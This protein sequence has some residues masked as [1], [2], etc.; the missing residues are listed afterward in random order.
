MDRLC[1]GLEKQQ[2][3]TTY[4]LLELACYLK[5]KYFF[6]KKRFLLTGFHSF[7]STDLLRLIHSKQ[8]MLR[9]VLMQVGYNTILLSETIN[10]K[11]AHS[12]A[13][14]CC[15]S[16]IYIY[17][18]FLSTMLL[19]QSSFLHFVDV[20][21]YKTTR[22]KDAVGVFNV[23]CPYSGIWQKIFAKTKKKAVENLDL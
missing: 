1:F 12:L 2:A 20:I 9:N 5:I 15:A 3:L 4:N 6:L 21:I 23:W 7:T 10:F 19:S 16:F 8:P 17:C 18:L 22:I 13:G 11:I 14:W